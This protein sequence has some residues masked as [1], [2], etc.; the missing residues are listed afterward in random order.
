MVKV[1]LFQIIRIFR[2]KCCIKKHF[3]FIL[4]YYYLLVQ[5]MTMH[6]TL[7]VAMITF[8]A[9]DIITWLLFSCINRNMR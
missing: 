5:S 3:G 9:E 7:V 8:P 4:V 2:N 1:Q 6:Y